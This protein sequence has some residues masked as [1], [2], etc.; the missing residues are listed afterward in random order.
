MRKY[1]E[2]MIVKGK[3]P[4]AG[5]KPPPF[6]LGGAQQ[7]SALPPLPPRSKNPGNT[8]A[9]T[10]ATPPGK[11]QTSDQGFRVENRIALGENRIAL[12]KKSRETR[13]WLHVWCTV[14][15]HRPTGSTYRFS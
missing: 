9:T 2:G 1:V 12:G 7:A 10:P 3:L 4:L 5:G 11:G 14:Y 15:T 8:L 6:R 13:V